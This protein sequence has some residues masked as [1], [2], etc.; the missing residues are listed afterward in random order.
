VDLETVSPMVD[1]CDLYVLLCF[2]TVGLGSKKGTCPILN[3]PWGFDGFEL[4][5]KKKIS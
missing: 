3:C 5:A 2:D 4:T 1:P